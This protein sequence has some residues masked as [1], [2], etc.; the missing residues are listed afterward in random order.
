M[1]RMTLF[2]AAALVVGGCAVR[3]VGGPDGWKVFGPP[4]PRAGAGAGGTARAERLRTAA[5][6]AMTLRC[7]QATQECWQNNRRV[8][9]MI[10]PVP[11]AAASASPRLGNGK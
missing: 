8:E 10:V 11:S 9:V 2:F 3:P 4:G 1:R 7:P 6:G 5:Y